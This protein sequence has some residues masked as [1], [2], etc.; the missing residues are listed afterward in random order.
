MVQLHESVLKPTCWNSSKRPFHKGG[1]L[2]RSW[3]LDCTHISLQQT[4]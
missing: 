2:S 4:F 3:I 1:L